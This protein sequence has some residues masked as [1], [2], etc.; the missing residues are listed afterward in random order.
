LKLLGDT[1]YIFHSVSFNLK[2]H[3][4]IVFQKQKTPI[5]QALMSFKCY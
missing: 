5:N 2:L 4:P 3:F 1:L